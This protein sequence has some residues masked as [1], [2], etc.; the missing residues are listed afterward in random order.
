V[1]EKAVTVDNSEKIEAHQQW[2]SKV[3]VQHRKTRAEHE[4]RSDEAKQKQKE[5]EESCEKCKRTPQRLLL[6]AVYETVLLD[7]VTDLDQVA[8][9]NRIDRD[10]VDFTWAKCWRLVGEGLCVWCRNKCHHPAPDLDFH[11]AADPCRPK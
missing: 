5:H 4:A 1:A 2:L 3:V 9:D 8:A 7:G 6:E 10:V 11:L